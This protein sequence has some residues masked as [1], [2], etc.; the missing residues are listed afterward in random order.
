MRTETRIFRRRVQRKVHF[1]QPTTQG[2]LVHQSLSLLRLQGLTPLTE[3]KV[4][5]LEITQLLHLVDQIILQ[6]VQI[7]AH[8]ACLMISTT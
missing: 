6:P 1:H 5:R 2:D 8:Q 3:V 7:L 4:H